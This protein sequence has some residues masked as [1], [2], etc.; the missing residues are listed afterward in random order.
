MKIFCILSFACL[1]YISIVWAQGN[2]LESAEKIE[3]IVQ[4]V[5]YLFDYVDYDGHTDYQ[6][7]SLIGGHGGG[8]VPTLKK[9]VG[10]D[11]SCSNG[12]CLMYESMLS[13]KAFGFGLKK[14]H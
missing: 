13:C 3:E 11:A 10:L 4:S 2:L 12:L 14:V 5:N 6:D 7:R 1:H 8:S 9:K